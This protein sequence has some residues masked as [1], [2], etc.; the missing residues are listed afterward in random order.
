LA[1]GHWK[2]LK[3]Q[4]SKVWLE[5]DFGGMRQW[6]TGF[7]RNM[8]W[9]YLLIP[10]IQEKGPLDES[11]DPRFKT[12]IQQNGASGQTNP[13]DPFLMNA[14]KLLLDNDNFRITFYSQP[15]NSPELKILGLGLVNCQCLAVIL[16]QPCLN[17]EFEIIAYVQHN[18]YPTNN[19]KAGFG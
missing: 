13:N 10:A 11:S 7:S 14:I 4:A 6:A 12:R 15:A 17:A 18:E 1:R 8:L 19:I 3:G 9:T 2:P 16:F 5:Q